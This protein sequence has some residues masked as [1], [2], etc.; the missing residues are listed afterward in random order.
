M[1]GQR[2][3]E[4]SF[5][6]S[7]VGP[8]TKQLTNLREHDPVWITGPLGNGFDMDTLLAPPMRRAVLVGGGVGAAPFPL[9]LDC[10]ATSASGPDLDVLVLLGFRNSSQAEGGQP[11]RAAA[12]RL[13]AGGASCRIEIATEDGSIGKARLVTDLLAAEQRQGDRLA[14]CGPQAMCE[15]VW[16]TAREASGLSCWFSLE[17][18]MACGVGSCHGCASLR[19]DGSLALVCRDGPVFTGESLYGVG[20]QE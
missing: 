16:Q 4:I 17:A 3:E 2:G 15:A 7:P 9:L 20:E 12:A 5:L 18:N 14:V 19:A 10:L 6:I 8:G 11:V 1:A 13:A